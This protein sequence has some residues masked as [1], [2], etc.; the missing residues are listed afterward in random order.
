MDRFLI[1]RKREDAEQLD[2][3]K[4]HKDSSPGPE[5][6]ACASSSPLSRAPEVVALVE[7]LKDEAWRVALQPEFD[8]SYFA[9]LATKLAAE[10]KSKTV[11]PPPENVFA[12]FNFTPLPDVRVV[13]LGQDPYHGTSQAHGLSFSVCRGVAVPPRCGPRNASLSSSFT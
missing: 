7:H 9:S 6:S 3:P 11:F 2:T 10:R 12:T 5:T 8:K 13:I 4:T 1:K